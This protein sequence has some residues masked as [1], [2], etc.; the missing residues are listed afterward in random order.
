MDLSPSR[1]QQPQSKDEMLQKMAVLVST[2]NVKLKNAQQQNGR[3]SAER[4]EMGAQL[5]QSRELEAAQAAK[6]KELSSI[7]EDEMAKLLSQLKSQEAINAKLKKGLA[8]EKQLSEERRIEVETAQL[9]LHSSK[10]ENQRMREEQRKFL[11]E[12]ELQGFTIGE[13]STDNRTLAERLQ[14]MDDQLRE[15][16]LQSEEVRAEA[17]QH[18]HATEHVARLLKTQQELRDEITKLQ[19]EKNEI[20]AELRRDTTQITTIESSKQLLTNENV[21]LRTEMTEQS[22]AI[23]A[24]ARDGQ[25]MKQKLKT[26]VAEAHSHLARSEMQLQQKLEQNKQVV[27]LSSELEMVRTEKKQMEEKVWFV[28]TYLCSRPLD[29]MYSAA[30]CAFTLLLLISAPPTRWQSTQRR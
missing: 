28:C 4:V 1:A 10:E 9:S 6:L 25:A 2:I 18:K 7:L 17:E 3:L 14:S 30:R 23:V 26:A 13:L 27:E 5:K 21:A 16:G 19:Q 12:Q 22:E 15:A 11:Q 24:L 20:A 29:L 8:A